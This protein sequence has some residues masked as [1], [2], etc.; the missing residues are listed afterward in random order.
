MR[1]LEHRRHTMRTKPGQHL[2]QAGVTLARKVGEEVGPFARVV[3]S[4]LLRA[5]ET[6]IAMG[7]AVDEQ[8]SVLSATGADVDA[9]IGWPP[10]TFARMAE[11]VR[12]GRSVSRFAQDQA[13]LLHHI[14]AEL[15]EGQAVLV[16]SHGGIVEL[17][18]IGCLPDADFAA[19]GAHCDYCEGV[20]LA[21][22][23][24]RCVSAEVLRV[25]S[26]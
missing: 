17:G 6:A 24:E 19:W 8:V 5:F 9:S 18:A 4:T 21:Y 1:Y 23:G 13:R 22:D 10:G 12:Q 25:N 2:S 26:A 3:T 14:V 16:I 15:S 11:V 7:F 20:R